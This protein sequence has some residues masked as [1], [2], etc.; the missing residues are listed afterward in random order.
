MTSYTL[1]TEHCITP[2]VKNSSTIEFLGE[3]ESDW[4]SLLIDNRIIR[5]Q[6]E[7]ENIIW[8]KDGYN[9]TVFES[10]GETLRYLAE[11][12]YI[13]VI[14]N[15]LVNVSHH[16]FSVSLEE[17]GCSDNHMNSNLTEELINPLEDEITSPSGEWED[18]NKWNNR[19]KFYR[20]L[21]DYNPGLICLS[22]LTEEPKVED[23]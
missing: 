19:W 8:D 15:G 23:Y 9:E 1:S 20:Y 6:I 11:K 3:E 5:I 13:S 17:N 10:Q 14:Y 16:S 2:N 22:D 12:R 21:S 7:D 4:G 18:F